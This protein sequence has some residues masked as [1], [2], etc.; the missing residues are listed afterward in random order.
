MSA[1]PKTRLSQ[2]TAAGVMGGSLHSSFRHRV[3]L[4]FRC[5][6]RTSCSKKA[7]MAFTITVNLSAVTYG[8]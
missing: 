1:E 7:K 4:S 2:R 3:S 6:E 5:E 8:A